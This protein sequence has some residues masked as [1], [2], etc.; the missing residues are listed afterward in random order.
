MQNHKECAIDIYASK[1]IE[2]GE[3][4][5]GDGQPRNSKFPR[6]SQG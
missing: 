4:I 6:K 5:I 1:T 3:V 2:A